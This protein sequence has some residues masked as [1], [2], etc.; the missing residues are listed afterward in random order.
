H[1]AASLSHP[2]IVTVYDT[3]EE[4]DPDSN[5]RVP[6]IVMELVN[7]KTLREIIRDGRKILPTRALQF[8]EGVLDALSYS[9]K[10]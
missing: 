9:H 5:V 7:G 4:Q 6:Y 10:A 8:T 3:G 2:N 1:A